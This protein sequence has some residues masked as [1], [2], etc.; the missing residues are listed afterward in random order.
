MTGQS[1]IHTYR[2]YKTL[3]THQI[4]A[5]PIVILMPHSACNCRCVMCDIWKDNKNLK[6]LTEADISGLLASL[7]QLGTKQVLMSGGEALLNTNFFAL[8]RILKNAGIS[9]VLLTTGL[10]IKANADQILEY[11]SE[12]IVSI[13]GDEPLHDAIRNIPNA[14]K[15]LKEGVE[16]IKNIAPSYRITGRTVI[17]RLNFRNW[18]AIITAGKNM[19]LNQMSFLPADVSSHAFNRQQAWTEPK[20]HE[21]LIA[22]RELPELSEVISDLFTQFDKEFRNGFIAESREKIQDIYHYYAAFYELNPFPFK[23]CNAPWVSVVVEA[24]GAVKP[25]FF[26]E[27]MGNIRD[28]SL[29]NILNSNE[30]VAFRKSLNTST[31]PTCVK[32]VC[33]LNLSPLTHLS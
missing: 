24:D 2:R 5:L 6:Q 29:G 21:I 4:T 19:G 32:C 27:A 25:C 9:V 16:H 10:S 15:K 1:I 28:T 8:C 17:H 11:V 26:M 30:A 18:P 33:S 14:F 31:H 20:Q 3:K 7:K 23:K 22:E 13:D 12:V